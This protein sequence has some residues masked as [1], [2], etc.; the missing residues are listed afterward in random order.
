MPPSPSWSVDLGSGALTTPVVSGNSGFTVG[1]SSVFSVNIKSGDLRWEFPVNIEGTGLTVP[2]VNEDLVFFGT[3]GQGIRALDRSNGKEVWEN[4]L[5][6][7]IEGVKQGYSHPVIAG[8]TILVVENGNPNSIS[9]D[10]ESAVR[11]RLYAL[12][13]STGKVKWTYDAG[14]AWGLEHA[15][16]PPVGISDGTVYLAANDVH[17]IDLS[18]GEAT[19]VSEAGSSSFKNNRILSPPIVTGNTVFLGGGYTGEVVALNKSDGSLRWKK[20]PA[21]ETET[22]SAPT[23][24]RD[25]VFVGAIGGSGLDRDSAP[26]VALSASDGSTVWESTAAL[27]SVYDPTVAPVGKGEGSGKLFFGNTALNQNTG[28]KLYTFDRDTS[29]PTVANGRIYTGGSNLSKLK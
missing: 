21:D 15:H 29:S 4:P 14:I 13:S 19:W 9:R 3:E 23:V 24:I 11:D 18:S 2:A 5:N 27:P 1:P 28:K 6:S 16:A 8:D 7:V 12:D 17:A 10:G 25:Q 20:A 26:V 22:W